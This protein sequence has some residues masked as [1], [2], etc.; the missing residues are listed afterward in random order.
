[1]EKRWRKGQELSRGLNQEEPRRTTPR[2]IGAD[3][4][5]DSLIDRGERRSTPVSIA[6]SDSRST[7]VSREPEI[8]AG[9]DRITSEER[10]MT[11]RST[12]GAI[13]LTQ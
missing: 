9:G 10:R 5:G 13:A 8:G 2:T 4:G 11:R 7:R 12:L 6:H 3:Q 1:M